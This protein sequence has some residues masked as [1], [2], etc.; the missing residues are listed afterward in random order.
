MLNKPLV[1]TGGFAE[2]RDITSGVTKTM[3]TGQTIMNIGGAL[4]G[5]GSNMFGSK[6]RMDRRFEYHVTDL[7]NYAEMAS[8]AGGQ[9]NDLMLS[10]MVG[11]R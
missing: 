6:M 4:M 1:E 9:A 3:E 5:K 2:I 8:H 7:G 11:M 10:Q